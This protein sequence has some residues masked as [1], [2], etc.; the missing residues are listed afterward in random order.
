MSSDWF[1]IRYLYNYSDYNYSVS[2][3]FCKLVYSKNYSICWPCFSLVFRFFHKA[4]RVFLQ[5]FTVLFLLSWFCGV[6]NA[7]ALKMGD[8]RGV[9]PLSTFGSQSRGLGTEVCSKCNKVCQIAIRNKALNIQSTSS[10]CISITSV[11]HWCCIMICIVIA[12]SS[13]K[14]TKT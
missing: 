14:N 10:I 3:T 2:I 8:L 5:Y 4:Y 6:A 12:V 9:D 7:G 11:M 1:S 13:N